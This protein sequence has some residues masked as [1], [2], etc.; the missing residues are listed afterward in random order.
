M[1]SLIFKK[2]IGLLYQRGEIRPLGYQQ[3]Q[4]L[5]GMHF[6]GWLRRGLEV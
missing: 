5:Q 1:L 3:G 6:L 4:V 2:E